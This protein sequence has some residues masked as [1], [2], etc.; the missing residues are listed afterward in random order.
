MP[1]LASS[2]AVLYLPT[3]KGNIDPEMKAKMNMNN[4]MIKAD[5]IYPSPGA[6]VKNTVN[7]ITVMVRM[8]S[9]PSMFQPWP[10]CW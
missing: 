7:I 8:D 6:A 4:G 10:W 9:N 5:S 3:A 1:A 2:P